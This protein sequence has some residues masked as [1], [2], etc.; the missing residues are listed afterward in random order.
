MKEVSNKL[1]VI[2]AVVLIIT[3]LFEISLF[4]EKYSKSITE[5]A[6]GL[7]GLCVD[8]NPLIIPIPPQEAYVDELF[9]YDVNTTIPNDENVTFYDDTPL[10]QIN[11]YTGVISFVPRGEDVG[12][13]Y[14]NIT[15]FSNCNRQSDTKTMI[16]TIKYKNRPPVLDPIPDFTINQ[17]ELFIYDVNASDPDNDTLF[18]GDNTTMFQ[19]NSQTGVIYF[20]PKQKDVG[21]HSVLIWVID[22]KGGIDWQVVNF[23]IIDVND[24]PILHTIGAQTAII[25]TIYTYDVNATDVDVKPEWNNLTFYDNA[26]FFDINATT[27]LI[28]FTVLE[29]YKGTYWINISVTDGEFWDFEVISFSVVEANHPPNI[30]S[31]YPE[32]GTIEINEG[33]SQYFNITKYDPD[34]TIPST[35]WYLNGRELRDETRDEFIFYTGYTSA[36][37]HN[38]TVVISDGELTDSHEWMVIVK[39][40]TPPT[41]VPSPPGGG[42]AKPPPCK[43]DWRCSEWSPCPVYEIQTRTCVDLNNCG[44]IYEKPEER[45]K[46]TYIPRANCSDGIINCHS[47]GCEIWIDCGGPCE[48]CPTCSDRKK[49]CHKITSTYILCEEDVDCGG[50]CPPCGLKEIPPVCGDLICDKGEIVSCPLDCGF[51]F[52]QF[53]L[54]IILIGSASLAVTKTYSIILMVYRKKIR[55]PPYANIQILAISTLRKLHLLQIEMGKKEEKLI[56]HEFARI[57][58]E[59]F[60]KAFDIQKKFTYIELAELARSRKLE[61]ELANQ[62]AEFSMLMTEMEYGTKEP[63]LTEIA[64]ALKFAI[65]I[66]EKISGLKL[67]EA[68][69]KRAEEQLKKLEAK[70]EEVKLKEEKEEPKEKYR[71]TEKDKEN[72][73]KLTE[74][75]EECEKLLAEHKIEEAE[76]MYAQIREIYNQL[77]DEVKVKLYSETVRII[78]IYNEIMKN[79]A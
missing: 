20:T 36:G 61:K 35:Q 74:L 43:E 70:K 59:F 52:A 10:F 30:T 55:P 9:Y 41:Y 7:V 26:T 39:D 12:T 2:L 13:H 33:Q 69:S 54:I 44:T 37:T 57:I 42:E 64:K 5:K 1:I 31:W 45:R 3:M 25:G 53:F 22:G 47:G 79:I 21:N 16:L 68:F 56:I 18:F 46:C 66:V 4:A 49:N 23:E 48:P 19:I 17:S 58:R 51:I 11:R 6:V 65:L 75:V 60:S 76:K 27:G 77:P 78:K 32:N 28:N 8:N 38:I 71:L 72:I 29:Q 62:I 67:Y 73:K 34:G 15:V 40:V 24:P 63:S 50:P 14:I